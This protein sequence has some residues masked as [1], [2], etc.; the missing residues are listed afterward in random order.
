MIASPT[1]RFIS[2]SVDCGTALFKTGNASEHRPVSA[3][4]SASTAEDELGVVFWG[5]EVCASEE[6]RPTSAAN[7]QVKSRF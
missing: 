7:T 2:F 4:C 5:F 6:A 3:K 1:F